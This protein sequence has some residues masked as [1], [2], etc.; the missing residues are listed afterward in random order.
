MKMKQSMIQATQMMFPRILIMTFRMNKVGGRKREKNLN[1][2]MSKLFM[3]TSFL[4]ITSSKNS[5]KKWV[6]FD[7]IFVNISYL[8]E[9]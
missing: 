9:I 1:I 5:N 7:I 8:F 2:S 4:A 3:T 6:K